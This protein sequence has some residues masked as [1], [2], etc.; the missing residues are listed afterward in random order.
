M[1]NAD[2]DLDMQHLEE[3]LQSEA[4]DLQRVAEDLQREAEDTPAL[5]VDF[6]EIWGELARRGAGV[7]V[8]LISK[9]RRNHRDDR[10]VQWDDRKLITTHHYNP[11]SPVIENPVS[12]CQLSIGG[13]YWRALQDP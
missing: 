2:E 4:E 6:T 13:Q 11:M 12:K 7:S 8:N 3:D 10:T 1:Q 5:S 9:G